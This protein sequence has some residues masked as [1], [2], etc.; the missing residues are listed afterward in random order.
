MNATETKPETKKAKAARIRE[1]A[2]ARLRE[3]LPPGADV[4][5]IMRHRAPSGMSRRFSLVM[6]DTDHDGK[7]YIRDISYTVAE[8][9]GRR[10]NGDHEIT[11]GGCGMDMG[12]HLVYTLGR[13]LYPEG[14]K[15]PKGKS[16]RNGDKSGFDTDGGYALNKRSL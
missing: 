2:C 5:T 6:I 11:V 1:E 4:Y 13:A 3:I 8:A 9:C 14:F 16:G 10:I 7:P 12:F 15:L